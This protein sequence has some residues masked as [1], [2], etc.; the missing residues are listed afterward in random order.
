M[1]LKSYKTTDVNQ[2]RKDKYKSGLM[3]FLLMKN[4][5]FAYGSAKTK[6]IIVS[7]IIV[8][9][10]LLLFMKKQGVFGT[11]TSTPPELFSRF[12]VFM[13]NGGQMRC[14]SFSYIKFQCVIGRNPRRWT[15]ATPKV[16]KFFYDFHI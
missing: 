7:V 5:V 3:L 13:L 14:H 2:S 15:V 1:F 16:E 12:S 9:V 8:L 4:K 6:T 10:V 11:G